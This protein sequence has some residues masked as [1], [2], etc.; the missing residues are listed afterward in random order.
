M[1]KL[2]PP[3]FLEKVPGKQVQSLLGEYNI[4]EIFNELEHRTYDDV[5]EEFERVCPAE[6]QFILERDAAEEAESRLEEQ[7]YH[8]H[9]K[10]AIERLRAQIAARED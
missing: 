6:L 10:K 3:A 5:K 2:M 8:I 4:L 1:L 9:L 7:K